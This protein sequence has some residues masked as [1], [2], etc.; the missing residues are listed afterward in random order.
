MTTFIGSINKLKSIIFISSLLASVPPAFGGL[1]YDL[2]A[3]SLTITPGGPDVQYNGMSYVPPGRAFLV[4]PAPA[5]RSGNIVLSGGAPAW[6]VFSAHFSGANPTT[7]SWTTFYNNSNPKT[8]FTS[9]D[10]IYLARTNPIVTQVCLFNAVGGGRYNNL[11]SCFPIDKLATP[12]SCTVSVGP[13]IPFGTV[14]SGAGQLQNA[15]TG[16]VRCTDSAPVR[17][18]VGSVGLTQS[19]I[20]LVPGQLFADM[21]INGLVGLPG[22]T[23]QAVGNSNTNFTVG[24]VLTVSNGTPGGAYRG[25]AVVQVEWF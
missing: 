23:L 1:V 9:P 3:R 18:T 20:D 22:A 15:V 19:R 10:M 21:T 11:G 12:N 16:S 14:P 24:A 13:E 25:N 4:Y 7:I 6:Q 17:V 2:N 5:D 8:V